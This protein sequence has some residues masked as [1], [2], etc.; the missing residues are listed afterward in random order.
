MRQ[1][2]KTARRRE[3]VVKPAWA[4]RVELAR[5]LGAPELMGQLLYNRGVSEASAARSFLRPSLHDLADP[6]RL[7]GVKEAVQRIRRA[8]AGG[9]KIVL[10][11][12][13]D[14]DGIAGVAILWRCLQL[15]GV[16]AG[17]LG[18]YVPHRI[19]EGYGLNEQAVRQLAAEGAKL[20]V[21]VDCGIGARGCAAVARELGVELIITDHHRV[22]GELPAAAAIVHPDLPGGDYPCKVL[23][24]A[25]V[26][27]K[28]AWALAQEF[29]A[30][31]KVRPEFREFLLT[32]TGL[33]AL[34]T[35]ADVVELVGENRVLSHYGLAGLAASADVGI[36][37]LIEAAGLTGADLNSA[38]IGFKLAPRL[39]AAGRMGHA[40]LALELFT[41]A[42]AERAREIAGYLEGQNRQRQQVEKAM[43][44]A[45]AEQVAALG[46]DGSEWRGIVVAAEGWHGGVLGLVASRLVERFGRPAVV[47]AVQGERAMGSCRS[48]AGFDIC[49]GLAACGELLESFGGHA[50]AA[51]LTLRPE[52]IE[53]FREAFNATARELL[54][55]EALARRLDI[56]AEAGLGELNVK[57]VELVER[58]G[59]FGAGNPSVVLAVRG[60]R[61]AGALRRIGTG[62]EHL[63]MLLA[64]GE[65]RAAEL[66]AGG[67]VRA[68][69]FG[70]GK[71]E[72]TLAGAE[73]FDVAFEPAIN[74]FN[75]KRTVEMIVQDV[76]VE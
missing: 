29:S 23:C 24:G 55:A 8:A 49:R 19:E 44:E 12:D 73:R 63:Q 52:R 33:A 41:R 5:Q 25:G 6:G 20:L 67:V 65:D 35:I 61:L 22:E 57:T 70:K 48:V 1:G 21:T 64:A 40:R 38:D 27:F 68:V 16:E 17:R 74:R 43:A 50:M 36:R 18:E 76:R 11:G 9:E 15:A 42:S 51:G 26:A 2:T 75:G 71:W 47:I 34:G 62:G 58:L 28:L 46:M 7:P 54:P 39:N 31:E 45:A 56:D 53:A 32:A 69:A 30:G 13:Y 66:R 60:V 37:A 10:Y 3:W 4:G 59:P 14:V 72:K